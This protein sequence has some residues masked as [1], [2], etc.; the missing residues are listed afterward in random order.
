MQSIRV[1][2][3]SKE[4]FQRDVQRQFDLLTGKINEIIGNLAGISV[5]ATI[6]NDAVTDA[7]LRNSAALSVVGRAANSIGDPADIA[8]SADET[9]LTRRGSALAFVGASGFSAYRDASAQTFTK[10]AWV[11]ATFNVEQFDDDAAFNPATGEYTAPRPGWFEF[12]GSIT[13]TNMADQEMLV[14]GVWLNGNDTRN[15]PHQWI[16]KNGQDS[17]GFV[18]TIIKLA[19]NDVVTLRL[20]NIHSVDATQALG[21]ESF[22]WFAGA[23]IR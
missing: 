14:C 1:D 17:A 22:N 23:Q 3:S 13:L 15:G 8:A 2:G 4:N 11:T 7:K 9:L 16:S 10:N 6:A 21:G 5:S 12:A 18:S 20:Y 19:L